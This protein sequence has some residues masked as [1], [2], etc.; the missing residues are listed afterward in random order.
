MGNAPRN[1]IQGLEDLKSQIRGWS[2]KTYGTIPKEINQIKTQIIRL[3]GRDD[4]DEEVIGLNVRLQCLEEVKNNYWKK[5][6]HSNWLANGDRNTT[7]FY[8][9]A[10]YRSRV[11]R[12]TSIRN[13]HNIFVDIQKAISEVAADYF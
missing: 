1:L 7:Y 13:S 10:N 5:I 11:N 4:V 12:I 3:E 6:S 8:H 9:H 2:F